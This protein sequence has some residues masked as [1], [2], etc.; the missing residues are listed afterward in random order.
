MDQ[1][2]TPVFAYGHQLIVDEDA[3]CYVDLLLQINSMQRARVRSWFGMS[4]TR[5]TRYLAKEVIR[6]TVV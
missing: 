6:L 5:P 2:I 4:I 1:V 3:A